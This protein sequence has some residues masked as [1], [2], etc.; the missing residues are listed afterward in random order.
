MCW[1]ALPEHIN[2]PE[3]WAGKDDDQHWFTAWRK[4]VKGWF[5][6]GPRDAHWYHRWREFPIVLFAL[7]GAG[8]SRWESSGGELRLR[9]LNNMILF[10]KPTT[11]YLSRIQYWCRWSIQLQWPLF[12]AFHFYFKPGPYGTDMDGKLFFFYVGAKRDADKVY[13]F[14]SIYVGLNWK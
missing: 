10:F 1:T 11:V 3:E 12:F 13:W 5:A 9:A 2:S 8:E 7:F 6:Y 14:P 4:A